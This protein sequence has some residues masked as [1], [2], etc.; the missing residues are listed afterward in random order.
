M[1]YGHS[2]TTGLAVRLISSRSLSGECTGPRTPCAAGL[3]RVL[4]TFPPGLRSGRAI[5]AMPLWTSQ[6]LAPLALKPLV[7]G[8]VPPCIGSTILIQRKENGDAERACRTSPLRV[9]RV[10]LELPTSMFPL[11]APRLPLLALLPLPCP[12]RRRS[13][14]HM[15]S[16]PIKQ[17]RPCSLAS[18]SGLA[19]VACRCRS[20]LRGRTFFARGC[21]SGLRKRPQTGSARL[22][23]S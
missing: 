7:L 6:L 22:W 17:L 11:P 3:T 9:L 16:K 10:E 21:G 23:P 18:L 8:A 15:S 12:G 19:R 1:P 2:A 14:R 5:G 13:W 4:C 20:T